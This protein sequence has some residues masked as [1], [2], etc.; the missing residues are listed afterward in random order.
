MKLQYKTRGMSAPKG[1]PKIYFACHPDDFEQAFPL[2]SEDLLRHA[3]CAVWYDTEPSLQCSESE[4]E[5]ILGEMRL[6][7]LAVTSRFLYENCRARNLELPLAQKLH[8]PV[9]P[10]LLENGLESAFNMICAQIQVVSKYNADPTAAPYDEVLQ[11]FLDSVLVG[12]DLAQQVRMA[13]DAYVFLSYRKK[14]R[15]HA[16][17]LMRL[18]HENSAF[19]DIAIWYD[20]YLV[21]G[22]GF[23]EAIRDAF[24]KSSLFAMTVTPHLEETGN[25]VMQIEYPMAR[26]RKKQEDGFEIVSVEMY[27]PDDSPEGKNW[28]INPSRLK[29]HAEFKYREIP[30]LK[31]EH[32]L[33]ELSS[34]F[35][36]ALERI[37]KKE[38][39]GSAQHRF[40]IGLAYLN[41]IDV[42][43]DFARALELLE[44]AAQDETPCIDAAAKLAQMYQNGEGVTADLEKALF[45]QKKVASQYKNAYDRNH[46]PAAHKGYGTA[47][48]KALRKLSDMQREAKDIRSALSSAKEALAFCEKLDQEVGVREQERDRAV[49]YNRLGRLYQD[50]GESAQSVS[51]YEK[52]A[53]TYER[54][55]YEIGTPRARRDLSIGY[56]RLGDLS[57][58]AGNPKKAE[59]YYGKTLRVRQELCEASN[60]PQA[61]RDLSAVLTKLGNIRKSLGDYAGAGSYYRQALAMDEILAEEIRTPQALDDYAVSLVKTGDI[62]K[63]EGNLR[64]AADLY[65]KAVAIFKENCEKTGSRIFQDHYASM[66]ERLNQK[67]A[68]QDISISLSKDL[69]TEEMSLS[70]AAFDDAAAR[71][72]NG[73]L[74]E[75]I[76]NERIRRGD[77]IL[78][79]YQVACEAIHGGMGSVWRVHHKNW[80]TDLAMKRPQPKYFAEGSG[81]RKAEFIAECENWINLGLHPNIVSCYYVREI[82]GVPTIFSEWM[83]GGSL[84]D[85]IRSGRLYAGREALVQERILDIAIQAMRGI[86]YSHK[87]GLIHQDIKPGNILLCKDWEARIADFGLAKAGSRLTGMDDARPAGYTLQYC[88]AQQAGGSPAKP[89]MD[90]YAWGVTVLEMY[91]GE[92]LWDTG[93]QAGESIAQLSGKFRI[94]IP[95]AMFSLLAECLQDCEHCDPEGIL[96]NLE[97]IY[98]DQH[99]RS[100]P[101]VISDTAGDTADRLNNKALSFLDLNC[102]EEA[103]KLWRKGLEEAPGHFACTYN[104]NLF[105]LRKGRIDDL[106]AI[107]KINNAI[108]ESGDANAPLYAALISLERMKNSDAEA[109]LAR[110]DTAGQD[111]EL[112]ERVQSALAKYPPLSL[113]EIFPDGGWGKKICTPSLTKNGR[114]IVWAHDLTDSFRIDIRDAQTG[115]S[116]QTADIV[117]PAQVKNCHVSVIAADDQIRFA[118]VAMEERSGA[119]I[120]GRKYPACILLCTL[121]TGDVRILTIPDDF[122]SHYLMKMGFSDDGETVWAVNINCDVLQFPIRHR[123]FSAGCRQVHAWRRAGSDS[124]LIGDCTKDGKLALVRER[125]LKNRENPD[126]LVLAD[127]QDGKILWQSKLPYP[128]SAVSLSAEHRQMLIVDEEKICHC[129]SLEDYRETDTFAIAIKGPEVRS[130]RMTENDRLICCGE[131]LSVHDARG[132][133]IR[134]FGYSYARPWDADPSGET[135]VSE[136]ADGF[137]FARIPVLRYA[138]D[139][140]VRRP[141]GF[142]ATAENEKVFLQRIDEA[143]NYI[144]AGRAAQAIQSLEN[145]RAVPGYEY[146]PEIQEINR[147]LSLSCKKTGIYN[148]NVIR[149]SGKDLGEIA[150][151]SDG[152][153]LLLSGDRLLRAD[154]NTLYRGSYELDFLTTLREYGIVFVKERRPFREGI[155]SWQCLD[156]RTGSEIYAVTFPSAF[157]ASVPAAEPFESALVFS[158]S[159]G[160]AYFDQ[161]S[162][163]KKKVVRHEAWIAEYRSLGNGEALAA[164]YYRGGREHETKCISAG[165]MD[166]RYQKNVLDNHVLASGYVLSREANK[167]ESAAKLVLWDPGTAETIRT[168]DEEGRNILFVSPDGEYMLCKDTQSGMIELWS[169]NALK[170][171]ADYQ[172]SGVAS[173]NA[174]VLADHNIKLY[175]CSKG[176][177]V[178][179]V[180]DWK[181]EG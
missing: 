170:K 48:F 66:R 165:T 130:L 47:Y 119:G 171:L 121:E 110:N 145:A 60:A 114:Y 116:V 50:L 71:L 135:V 58:K 86:L 161:K 43:V 132:R 4:A 175:C 13:F 128:A 14:D 21:P 139:W 36:D 115:Q 51:C 102:P 46:D 53:A 78:Q 169:V 76:S 8:V 82:G 34:A 143:R 69:V 111:P 125:D 17:R 158:T 73:K 41:G 118:A 37:A 11:G 22:E 141:F 108:K 174:A 181:F 124:G 112:P 106:S 85:S 27:D 68:S 77:E 96:R 129:C 97:E 38:H 94:P 59:E 16:Q 178:E 156:D 107:D 35:L 67:D 120:V 93:A 5:E 89:W 44:S 54:L 100:Y 123:L 91:A 133:C 154:G 138:A 95:H 177:L 150:L 137:V 99:G 144:E 142:S 166:A 146:A 81:Q 157:R 152:K 136:S 172:A 168:S 30:D 42:E 20:E 12:D 163:T 140:Y 57:R 33:P 148:I 105:L 84:R 87:K 31:D 179:N 26:D 2:I 24:Q 1:K 155:D 52:A 92:R 23:N 149:E 147:Q 63:A 3:N 113:R 101:R 72:G 79:T 29:D 90:I 62:A 103:E 61:R 45:W 151:A 10:I 109:Y 9:L 65:E 32:R 162:G 40:F 70:F 117:T 180:I 104:L 39:D 164:L 55:V 75:M 6:I 19:R 176:V 98:R 167:G 64:E 15:R 127:L 88:P 7:V 153:I 74:P 56:E 126:V 131:G 80:N 159:E 25:Y 28:R 18:I 160:F 173:Y 122:K 83:D 49:I 134:T